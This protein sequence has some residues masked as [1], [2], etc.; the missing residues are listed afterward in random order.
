[1]LLPEPR[2][3][4]KHY[5]P[6]LLYSIPRNVRLSDRQIATSSPHRDFLDDFIYVHLMMTVMSLSR[7]EVTQLQQR[8]LAGRRITRLT[9]QLTILHPPWA[10]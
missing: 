8:G 1:M 3:V 2:H 5:Q 10:A 4:V 9:P 6:S 7:V